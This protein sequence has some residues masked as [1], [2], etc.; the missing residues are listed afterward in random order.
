[1]SYVTIDDV[2]VHY[3]RLGS[4]EPL[5][6]I[7]GLGER[8]EGWF[9]QHE[10][11]N[12]YELIIP[13]LPGFGQS[14][15]PKHKVTMKYYAEIVINLM[16]KLGIESAHICGL[17]MGG[18]VAQELYKRRKDKVRK[19]IL[20]NTFFYIPSW[21]SRHAL[22]DRIKKINSMS[23]KDYQL[24]T[25]YSG[26]YS[27]NADIIEKTMHIWSNKSD[28]Y[29]D[30][31]KECLKSNF[32]F[33]LGKIKA[34]TLIIGCT[35]DKV[36][37]VSIQIMMNYMIPRSKL[38]IIDKAGHLGKVEKSEEFNKIILDFLK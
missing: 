22:N 2:D 26:I 13:D 1:M 30:A 27:K 37:P 3:D 17:S 20:S 6:L 10:L 33:D 38:E 34:E 24:E 15:T 29:V 14:T 31:S 4:G 35:Y 23:L 12:N 21:M 8:K 19:L 9:Y 18:V 36:T 11:A 25:T 7:H 16:D 32:T 28:V 5:V